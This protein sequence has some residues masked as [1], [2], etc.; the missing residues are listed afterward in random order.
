MKA[1]LV[2]GAAMNYDFGQKRHWRKWVWNRISER[3]QIPKRDALVLYLAGANDFDRPVALSKG[4]V[5]NNLIAVE[6]NPVVLEG[7]RGKGVL[8]VDANFADVVDSQHNRR[9]LDVIFGDFCCGLDAHLSHRIAFWTGGSNTHDAVF[10]FNLLRG[11]D[12]ASKALRETAQRL[13]VHELGEDFKHRGKLLAIQV[14]QRLAFAIMVHKH[15]AMASGT[16]DWNLMWHAEAKAVYQQMN[17][18]SSTYMSDSGQVMDSIVF[19]GPVRAM[20]PNWSQ[21][22]NQQRAAALEE[23]R[24]K[25]G[26]RDGAVKKASQSMAAVM[27]HRTMRAAA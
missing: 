9:K 25:M 21:K 27:A 17:P 10:A 2:G 1:T 26:V 11:R 12:P 5:G 16:T 19:T 20:K 7:L 15:K 4:F 14:A 22:E 8:A 24:T 6:K 18:A 23:A 3:V 13:F